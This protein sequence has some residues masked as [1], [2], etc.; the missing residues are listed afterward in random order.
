MFYSHNKQ[1]MRGNDS[2]DDDPEEEEKDMR[3]IRDLMD[4]EDLDVLLNQRRN[5]WNHIRL[6]WDEHVIQLKHE[7]R[8][9]REYRMSLNAFNRLK[10]LL[11]PYLRRESKKRNCTDPVCVEF[12][13]GIG[14][15]YLAGRA[16][17]EIRH[18]FKT[19]RTKA[20]NCMKCFL[21]AVNCCPE[22]DIRLPKEPEEVETLRKGFHS[23]SSNGLMEGCVGAVDGFFQR[24]TC[25][26]KKEIYNSNAYYSG[27]YES[28]GLN[29]QALCDINQRFLFFGVVAP[30]KTNDNAAYPRCF[31]LKHFVDNLPVGAYI[32]GDAAYTLNEKLLTPFTG[33][34]KENPH[35]DAF[36]FH[37][38]Q[39]RIRIE[40]AFGRLVT[41]FRILKRKLE[42]KLSSMSA[43]IMAC[44]RLH[45]YI[46]D[47]DIIDDDVIQD[48]QEDQIVPMIGAP[49][50]MAYLPMMLEE[51]DMLDMTPGFSH[52]RTLLVDEIERNDYKRPQYNIIRASLENE[53]GIDEAFFH[54][55]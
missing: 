26:S 38:S 15:R 23:M 54:P 32:V 28:H 7:N 39:L 43:I 10:L 16:I 29:C 18:V 42:G 3:D 51:G 4:L 55:Q 17:S 36:N 24:I 25:P 47:F 30:G 53:T 27:H 14:L 19:S 50:G 46:I 31:A 35:K 2:E 6:N 45:N 13:M 33:T 8:F 22:L 37:L 40:M 5:R 9:Q 1:Q 49:S 20:Y 12:I 11:F 44:A 52:L 41:K 21:D 34:Q 48:L